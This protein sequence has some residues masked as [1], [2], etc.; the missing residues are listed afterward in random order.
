MGLAM[1]GFYPVEF[2]DG[3]SFRWASPRFALCRPNQ[4]R[5][6]DLELGRPDVSGRLTAIDLQNRSIELSGGWHWY[7]LDL[8]H[9]S[10]AE[11]HFEVTPQ[12]RTSDDDRLLGVMVRSIGWHSTQSRHLA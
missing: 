11:L 9:N 8:G 1:E 12:V 7:S 3:G 5:Y 6:L 2:G 10:P 4:V